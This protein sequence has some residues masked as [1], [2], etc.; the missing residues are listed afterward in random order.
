M[1]A[2]L[3]RGRWIRRAGGGD[4]GEPS[5][6]GGKGDEAGLEPSLR[7][8]QREKVR[9]RKLKTCMKVGIEPTRLGTENRGH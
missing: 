6:T 8:E 4:R 2:T 7:K 5:E 1:C 3:L 9:A